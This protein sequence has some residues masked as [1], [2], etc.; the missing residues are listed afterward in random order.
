MKGL[1]A[2]RP[3]LFLPFGLGLRAGADV[4]D[5]DF[6][7]NFGGGE[8][9]FVQKSCANVLACSLVHLRTPTCGAETR[10]DLLG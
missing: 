2:P 10:A 9:L 6:Y 4:R 3:S 5:E 1:P 8:I 7:I